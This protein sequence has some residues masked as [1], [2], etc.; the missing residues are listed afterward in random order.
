MKLKKGIIISLLSFI[1]L[2][3]VEI[4]YRFECKHSFYLPFLF[5]KLH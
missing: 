1:Y 4:I 3:A 2:F 5:I